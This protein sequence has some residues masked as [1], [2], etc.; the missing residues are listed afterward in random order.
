MARRTIVAL[1]D[2]HGEA[3]AAR[4]ELLDAGFDD[5]TIELI[6]EGGFGGANDGHGGLYVQL[7]G[8]GLPDADAHLYAEGVRLG[9]SLLAVSL[10][11][12]AAV[13]R[14]LAVLG[15]DAAPRRTSGVGLYPAPQAPDGGR[16]PRP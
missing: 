4:K 14:A 5:L 3:E 7:A 8:W 11:R 10:L 9:G 6:S 15:A 13:E 16:E 12:T 2:R 1:Y